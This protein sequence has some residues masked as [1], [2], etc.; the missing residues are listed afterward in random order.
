MQFDTHY[1]ER[2]SSYCRTS[3][4]LGKGGGHWTHSGTASSS[5]PVTKELTRTLFPQL[6]VNGAGRVP[7]VSMDCNQGYLSSPE[8]EPQFPYL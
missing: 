6:S 4:Q 7:W 8:P 1:L 3:G 2:W 5:D